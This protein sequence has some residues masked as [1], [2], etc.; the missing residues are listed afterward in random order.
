M[1]KR[2]AL[3][4]ALVLTVG[5]LSACAEE[6]VELTPGVDITPEEL[7]GVVSVTNISP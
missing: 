4:L 7:S 1:R 5:L 6:P 2:I 3:L